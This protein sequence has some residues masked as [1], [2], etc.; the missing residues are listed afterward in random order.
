MG[1]GIASEETQDGYVLK[2]TNGM[3]LVIGHDLSCILDGSPSPLT[4]KELRGYILEMAEDAPEAPRTEDKKDRM[5]MPK[6]AQSANLAP[7][8]KARDVQVADLTLDDIKT[9]L[10]P[11]AT[12]QEAF[13]F[14]KLCQARGMNPFLKEAYLIKY[15][16][17]APA[18][19]VVGKEHFTMTAERNPQFDGFEAGIIIKSSENGPEF[20]RPGAFIRDG[21]VL[22][23]GWARVYR[24]DKGRPFYNEA[25]LKE[26]AKKTQSGKAPWDLMPGVMIRKVALVQSLR[27]AFPNDL[28][29]CYDASEVQ[30]DPSREVAA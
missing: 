2:A 11:K 23:G 18:S 19:M 27:E 30:V 6:Q 29:G 3:T 4:E 1:E 9:Y 12:D 22:I 13:M 24:K 7:Q 20:E 28:A 14:L 15:S 21:E 8:V 10:C 26:F 5:I 16:D 17:S 25:N